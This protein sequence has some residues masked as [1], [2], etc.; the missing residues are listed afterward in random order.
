MFP[1]PVGIECWAHKKSPKDIDTSIQSGTQGLGG[2]VD[3]AISLQDDG[4]KIK[5]IERDIEAK[6][7]GEMKK[8]E[9]DIDIE[10][11]TGVELKI[12]TSV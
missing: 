5:R 7:G 1:S 9:V 2:V 10:D 3:V 11:G 4:N 12:R 8:L 6:V